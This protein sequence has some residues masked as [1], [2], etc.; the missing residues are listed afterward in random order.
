[1][2]RL[3]A[4][5][6]LLLAGGCAASKP[7]VPVA[8]PAPLEIGGVLAEDTILSG[9]YLLV[10]DLQ[11]PLGVTLTILPGTRIKVVHSDS[12]KI[13]PEYLS[14][15]TEILVRG[16]LLV[17]GTAEQPVTIIPDSPLTTDSVHWAGI[18][19]VGDNRSSLE[20]LRLEQAE[21]GLLC[22]DSSPQLASVAILR[23]RYGIILQ[24]QSAPR[25]DRLLLQDGEGGLFCWDESAPV[26][27]NS[28]LERHSEE[29]LY[30]GS[31][32]QLTMT[33]TR[34]NDNDRGVV[35]PEGRKLE[36]TNQ[37]RGNRVDLL[38]YLP[39]RMP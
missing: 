4:F 32:C 38:A 9:D 22:L 37:I 33:N 7:A 3:V 19:L 26:M 30:L 29:A 12:T 13:D 20:H 10:A 39:E 6:L 24:Q 11:V 34:I 27:N 35:L 8:P 18:A 31:G 14:R 1:M 2:I 21:T 15:E 36:G 25:I 28:R 5:L 16:R 17:Q 23:S